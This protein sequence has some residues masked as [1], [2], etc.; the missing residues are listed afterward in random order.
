MPVKIDSR[1]NPPTVRLRVR[2]GPGMRGVRIPAGWADPVEV[3]LEG[4]AKPAAGTVKLGFGA[5][6]PVAGAAK[7]VAGAVGGSGTS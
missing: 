5:V 7:P 4:A 6:K 3:V 2:L 1:T